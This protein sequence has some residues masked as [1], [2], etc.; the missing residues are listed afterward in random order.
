MPS[1]TAQANL[2]RQTYQRAGLDVQKDRCQY[3]EAHGTGTKAGDP[4]EAGAIY[5]AFFSDSQVEDAN[6]KLYVGSIK[7]VIGHTEGTAGLAGLL[8]AGLAVKHGVIPPNMLL[9]E[10]N[11]D[12]LPYYGRLEILKSAQAWPELP[13]GVPR[14]ASVNS[15]G[16]GGANAHAI[17]EAYEPE[18]V[19]NALSRSSN[20]S[21][22]FMFSSNSEKTLITQ[23]ETFLA[24]I[25]TLDEDSTNLRDLAWTLSRRSAFSLRASYSASSL[26]DLRTKLSDAIDAKKNDGSPIGERPSHKTH[27]ILGIFTGQGA[28][29]PRMGY[30]LVESSPFAASILRKLDS[31]LQELPEQDRPAWTL[32]EEL[33][34][35]ADDSHVMEGAYSQPLCAAVQVILI[36]L[37]KEAGITFDVVVGHSSGEIGAAYAAGFL[38]ARDAVRIAYYRGLFGKLAG[39]AKGASGSMLAVG[40]SMEDATELCELATMKKY[41]RFNVAASNSSSSVTMSGDQAAIERAKFIFEDESKFV[42]ALKVDTAYHSHHMEPCS[43]PYMDAMARVGIEIQEPNPSCRWYSSVLG[44]DLVTSDMKEKLAGSYW[45]DNLLQPVLFSQALESALKTNGAPAIALEVGPHPALKGPASMVIEETLGTSVP[46]LG[47]LARNSDDIG[48]FSGAIGSLWANVGALNVDFARLDAAFVQDSLD[49]PQFLRSVP[50]YTWEHN[51]VFWTESRLSKAMRL[52]QDEHHELLGVRIDSG[53]NERR[54]RNFLKP[55]EIPWVRGHQI[56]GQ[57]VFPGAGF[58]SMAIEATKA[59]VSDA[60]AEIELIEVEDLT[61]RRGLGFVDEI[62]G[63]EVTI[64]L[65]NIQ[66]DETANIIHC[67][68]VCGACPS[69]DAAPTTISTARITIRLGCGSPETLPPREPASEAEKMTDVDADI[70]YSS[71]SK[72]GYNYADMFKSITTLS[73]RKLTSSGVIHTT[74][75][76]GYKSDLIV[77]PAPLDV[78]FQGMF[79]AIGAP[80]DGQLWTLMVPTVIKSIKVN[81]FMCSQTACL[82]TDLSFDARAQVDKSTNKVAGDIDVYD[83]N[84]NAM[85][86]IEG[87]YVT[88]LTQA[89]ASDDAQKFTQTVYAPEKPDAARQYTE[90]WKSDLKTWDKGC[91]VER[92]CFHYMKLLHDAI[93]I[94]EREE[95]AWHPKKY[96]TWATSVVESV[97]AGTHPIV[98]QE[99][100]DDSLESLD[101]DIKAFTLQYDDFQLVKML[102][103]NLIAFVKGEV[104]LLELFRDSDVLDQVYKRTYGVPEYNIYIGDLVKQLSHKHQQMEILEIGAGTGSATEGIMNQIGDHFGSY[105]FTDI[106]ASFF[107]DAQNL[108]KKHEEKFIYK[109]LNVETDPTEQGFS[110]RRY[111]LIIASNVLHATKSINNTLSNVRRLLKPG[112]RLVLLEITDTDPVR[113]TFFFGALPGWWVGEEDG[114]EHHPLLRQQQWDEAL[115]EAGFSGIDTATPETGMFIVPLSVMMSQAIDTQMQLI[116]EPLDTE[117]NDAIELPKLLLLAGQAESTSDLQSEIISVLEPFAGEIEIVSRLEDLDESHFGPKQLVLSLMELDTHVFSPFTA[118]RWSAIQLLVENSASILWLT[119]GINGENPF[120]NMMNGVARCLVHEKPDLRFQLVDFPVDEAIDTAYVAS[121]LL[122][123]HVSSTWKNFLEPYNTTWM[124]ERE[125]RIENGQEVIPRMLPCD[126]L[127]AR[128]NASR[129]TIRK[130]VD[131]KQSVVT[132]TND[133]CHFELKEVTAP[134]WS[135]PQQTNTV[136]VETLQ[137]TLLALRIPSVGSLHLLIGKI[138]GTEKKVLAFSETLQSKL[139]VPRD[140][141]FEVDVSDDETQKLLAS[142][143]NYLL[144]AYLLSNVTTHTSLLVHEPMPSLA[145]ALQ[146]LSGGLNVALSLTTSSTGPGAAAGLK[147]IH[148]R[149]HKRTVL[150]SLPANISAFAYFSKSEDSAQAGTHVEK[151]LPTHISRIAPESFLCNSIHSKPQTESAYGLLQNAYGFFEAHSELDYTERVQEFS[152]ENISGHALD[153][154]QFNIDVLNFSPHSEPLALAKLSTAEDIVQFR[155]DKTYWLAG[156][157]GELGLSLTAWMIERG[158]RYIVLTSRNPKINPKWLDAMQSTGATVLALPM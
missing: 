123:M 129:R 74:A 95:L 111:D 53:E 96:I 43:E 150:D 36:E 143:V 64:T 61:I 146:E 112:G 97:K 105:T 44:G 7:T 71:L 88:P 72:Q 45:K 18:K 56:Q 130:Q 70:F 113:Q 128:Y 84:G 30:M 27:Q 86:Q 40:T 10:L 154:S 158:A 4:Q 46:Y 152:L 17:I 138:A 13:A 77:H 69:K 59:F 147:Y 109:T 3:F 148:P 134:S 81:P 131:I 12:V 115:L 31:S 57:T 47:V 2:I 21:V 120:S 9:E 60:G 5:K 132:I 51:Q 16:F 23:L 6:D 99:W 1:S 38:T 32:E 102:G 157:T 80:G 155:A 73:R 136:E 87:L 65:S 93:P 26:Q 52:R 85:L 78:A 114:R 50:G 149:A 22:P 28:Q 151:Y 124:L 25:E 139:S 153:K 94:E 37:L 140:L 141:V 41:G 39:G 76:E 117:N 33:S 82:E 83:I 42:R 126:A 48:V 121:L 58:A 24:H 108:F 8:R 106:S 103:D 127:D 135:I 142:A 133:N 66:R 156:L 68:F 35:S 110:E 20:V 89:G 125:I 19:E 67:D 118:E 119:R 55:N 49:K 63:A 90:F 29:W 116:R 107:P 137:S 14:R 34:K 92:V 101:E 15:F 104:S 144:G 54:W 75:E 145:V 98:K 79:G 91:F 122:R 100:L 62:T 11:P